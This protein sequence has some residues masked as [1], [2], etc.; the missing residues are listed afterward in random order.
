[1]R[2]PA[3]PGTLALDCA[4]LSGFIEQQRR[5]MA[6]LDEAQRLEWR[7]K[8][9][10]ATIIEATHP[11]VDAA[12]TTWILSRVQVESVTKDAARAASALLRAANL[13]G[14]KYAIDA[15]VAEMALRQRGP[16]ALI[17]SD[18][19]DMARLCGPSVRLIPL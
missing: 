10:A 14:H 17:T 12:R 3:A 4:G 5:V 7:V 18:P 8:T 11:K 13:H 15:M 2:R 6:V 1:M 9:C 16:V 19:D